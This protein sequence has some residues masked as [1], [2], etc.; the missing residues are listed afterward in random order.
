MLSMKKIMA[1]VALLA[2]GVLLSA[3]VAAQERGTKDDAKAL[4]EKAVA[5]YKAHGKEAV[6]AEA[7]KPD[8]SLTDRDLYIFIVNVADGVR[9]AHAKNAK[10]VGKSI[11]DFKDVD[12]KPY[13]QEIVDL[14]KAA[15]SGWV[16]Y[17]FTDP[18]T[19]K[20]GDKT[21]YILRADDMI[22]ASGAYK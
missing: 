17:K 1:A 9:L 14:G 6:I 16:D 19:K 8:G 10:L 13:G 3:P 2:V 7:N 5:F 20:I 15:G 12:G 21:T 11:I 18:V 4:V 22:F